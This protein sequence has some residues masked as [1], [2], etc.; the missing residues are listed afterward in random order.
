MCKPFIGLVTKLDNMLPDQSHPHCKCL[1]IGL[2]ILDP[3]IPTGD[4]KIDWN[5]VDDK[6][7]NR[8]ISYVAYLLRQAIP[9]PR[10]L[11]P[12]IKDAMKKNNQRPIIPNNPDTTAKL[13]VNFTPIKLKASA[14]GTRE[15]QGRLIR[16]GYTRNILNEPTDLFAT[17][18]FV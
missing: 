16:A 3:R 17:D 15:Y 9:I 6:A 8:W 4:P 7:L 11:K 10:I 18:S 13:S 12:L 5:Q 14:N 1:N 2:S